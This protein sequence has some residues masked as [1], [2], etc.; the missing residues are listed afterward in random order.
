MKA[1][2]DAGIARPLR[3]IA[4]MVFACL[5]F[6]LGDSIAKLLVASHSVFLIVWLK[7]VVQCLLVV[8]FVVMSGK[9]RL[10]KTARPGVQIARGV[11]GIGSYATFVYAISFIPLADAVAIEFS[12]PIIVVALCVPLLG[13]QVGPRRWLAVVIGFLGT[14]LIVRPGLGMVHWAASLMLFAALCVALMQILSRVLANDEDPLTSLFYL[15]VTGLVVATP[16]VFFIELTS[17]SLWECA[18]MLAVGAIAGFCHYLFV[19]AYDF[20]SASLL[21]PF[22]Y[23]QIIGATVLGYV[24]FADVPDVYTATGTVILVLSGLYIAARERQQSH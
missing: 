10:F 16:M 9:T 18:L 23:A 13:E 20:A 17:L 14:L 12:S 2:V 24:M 5:L 1:G 22:M 7:Y 8:L 15:S 11:A 21:A 3:G 4:L 6:P 19:H